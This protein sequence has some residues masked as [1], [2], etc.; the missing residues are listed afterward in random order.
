MAEEE[1]EAVIL[2][3][4]SD[5]RHYLPLGQRMAFSV[6]HVL[7]GIYIDIDFNINI[8]IDFNIDIDIELYFIL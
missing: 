5:N 7:N 6:G 2:F 1:E 4:R 3:R 8:D